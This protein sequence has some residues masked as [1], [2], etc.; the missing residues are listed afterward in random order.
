MQGN[1][2]ES[3]GAFLA[4]DMQGHKLRLFLMASLGIGLKMEDI[5]KLL[6]WL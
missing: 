1:H 6:E 2:L 4:G 5:Q 3:K